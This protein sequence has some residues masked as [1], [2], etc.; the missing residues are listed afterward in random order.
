[1]PLTEVQQFVL[2]KVHSRVKFMVGNKTNIPKI[3]LIKLGAVGDLVMVSPFFDQLRKHFPH[4]EIVLVV[5]RS[6]YTA[7]EHN[8]S[9]TR[10]ILADDIDLYRGG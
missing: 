8:P 6:S 2:G 9:I 7:V 4:S 10:F 1:M 5:G 3:L